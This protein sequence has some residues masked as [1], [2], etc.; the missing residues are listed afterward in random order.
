MTLHKYL[1]VI[2]FGN[3]LDLLI[4]NLALGLF[5]GRFYETKPL[6]NQPLISYP[7]Y[8]LIV[9]FMYYVSRYI[10]GKTEPPSKLLN[11]FTDILIC[12]I[13]ILP[14][15]AFIYNVMVLLNGI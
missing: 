4:T 9:C 7:I 8:I 12:G 10:I 14:Y 3:F 6:G 13:V 15:S 5:P 2:S 1:A 11:K